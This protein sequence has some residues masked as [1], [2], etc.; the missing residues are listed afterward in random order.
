MKKQKK[1]N[2]SRGMTFITSMHLAR[3]LSR[4]LSKSSSSFSAAADEPL[5]LLKNMTKS[6][7]E[8]VLAELISAADFM[9]IEQ[10]ERR[11][12]GARRCLLEPCLYLQ[13]SIQMASPATV[14]Q[15]ALSA[16]DQL[17]ET[18]HYAR[19]L[20]IIIVCICPLIWALKIACFISGLVVRLFWKDF[21]KLL[22]DKF[23]KFRGLA[24]MFAGERS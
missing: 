6:N 3:A 23:L 2:L 17:K 13:N 9:A 22:S 12:G 18:M 5:F 10:P 24:E 7:F 4:A 15:V 11:L 20:V 8:P 16:A 1:L 19:F 14:T 21:V